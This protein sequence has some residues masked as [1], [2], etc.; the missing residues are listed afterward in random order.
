MTIQRSSIKT[1]ESL[2]KRFEVCLSYYK[3]SYKSE[4]SIHRT[5]RF[6][7]ALY[8]CKESQLNSNEIA[9]IMFNLLV[10]DN[11]DSQLRTVFHQELARLLG[12]PRPP[13]CGSASE[14]LSQIERQERE[15]QKKIDSLSM[16]RQPLIKQTYLAIVINGFRRYAQDLVARD[17]GEGQ[18][19]IAAQLQEDFSKDPIAALVKSRLPA[20]NSSSTI[21]QKAWAFVLSAIS[22]I[23]SVEIEKL[24]TNQNIHRLFY[25]NQAMQERD[26][27]IS[28]TKQSP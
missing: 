27:A 8:Y 10:N 12:C 22:H 1:P 9:V 2:L 6:Q 18:E 24:S 15:M 21:G 4:E 17:P 5:H 7:A 13:S 16:L 23:F 14:E 19:L 25:S 20:Q 3:P 28:L 11:K 26:T